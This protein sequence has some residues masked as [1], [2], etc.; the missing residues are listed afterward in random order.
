[1]GFPIAQ[2]IKNLPVMKETRVR[3]LGQEDSLEKGMAPSPVLLPGESHGQRSLAGYSQWDHKGLDMAEQLTN[4]PINTPLSAS[5][6]QLMWTV[7]LGTWGCEYLLETLLSISSGYSSK[8]GIAWGRGQFH[9]LF[10]TGD[11]PF[12]LPTW[13]PTPV[14]LSGESQGWGSLVGCHL[15]GRTESDMTEAT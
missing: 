9:L 3:F 1:M 8:C 6:S 2:M 13:Q 12:Y 15:W 5:K 7:L 4:S 14:F 10:S 11:A